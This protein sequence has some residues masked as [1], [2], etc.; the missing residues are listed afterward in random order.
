MVQKTEPMSLTSGARP[1]AQRSELHRIVPKLAIE[2]ST[3]DILVI[4]TSQLTAAARPETL[5]LSRD[6]LRWKRDYANGNALKDFANQM[7][8]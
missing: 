1:K 3:Y 8:A 5:S 4:D 7:M 2:D 6:L